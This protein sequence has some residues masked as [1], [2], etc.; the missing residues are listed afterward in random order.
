MCVSEENS[1]D[2]PGNRIKQHQHLHENNPKNEP[3]WERGAKQLFLRQ[4]DTRRPKTLVRICRASCFD[5]WRM[6][7][8]STSDASLKY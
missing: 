2:F 1:I 8:S 4:D 5:S 6:L 7:A 3:D